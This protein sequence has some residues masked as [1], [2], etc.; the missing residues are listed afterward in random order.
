[1]D[2]LLN[3]GDAIKALKDGKAIART[4]WNG[5]GMFIYYVPGGD[6]QTQTHIA[7]KAFGVS[8]KYNPYLAIKNVNDTV[9]TWIPSVNDVLAEDWFI[10]NIVE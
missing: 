7:K 3:F 9:S 10:K 4:G 6:Y 8:V 5:K 2:E 1:M